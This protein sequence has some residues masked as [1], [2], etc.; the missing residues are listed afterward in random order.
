MA[1]RLCAE[2]D[3]WSDEALVLTPAKLLVAPELT[4]NGPRPAEAA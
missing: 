4:E 2:L 3:A 1:E